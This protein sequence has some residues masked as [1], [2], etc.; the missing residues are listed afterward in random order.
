MRLNKHLLFQI[1]LIFFCSVC[2][3]AAD[4]VLHGIGKKYFLD[5]FFCF[6]PAQKFLSSENLFFTMQLY[7]I[8]TVILTGQTIY[9]S[10]IYRLKVKKT[11]AIIKVI[12]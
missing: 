2:N 8:T 1:Y 5:F 11:G 9:Y 3:A 6:N 7:T 12:A 4:T 10:H